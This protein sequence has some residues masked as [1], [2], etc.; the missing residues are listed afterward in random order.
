RLAPHLDLVP[1]DAA[2]AVERL[3]KRFFDREA[4]RERG[5]DVATGEVFAL[6]FAADAREEAIAVALERA[7]HAVDRADVDPHS[8][9]HGRRHAASIALTAP[10]RPMNTASAMT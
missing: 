6:R 9:D 1:A 10:P 5:G 2:C 4:T 8:D 3:G 7:P